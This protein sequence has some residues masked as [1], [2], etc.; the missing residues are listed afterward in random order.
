MGRCLTAIIF[1]DYGPDISFAAG[2]KGKLAICHLLLEFGILSPEGASPADM[3]VPV[4]EW[5]LEGVVSL[6][7]VVGVGDDDGV[8][9]QLLFEGGVGHVIGGLLLAPGA[10]WRARARQSVAVERQRPASQWMRRRWPEPGSQ[11]GVSQARRSATCQR[12]GARGW[13][14]M[15]SLLP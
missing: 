2:G 7:E 9:D 15:W 12:V 1:E 5:G 10:W 4:G 8:G 11:C 3:L 13:P 6:E 14:S